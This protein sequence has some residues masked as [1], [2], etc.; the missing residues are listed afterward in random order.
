MSELALILALMMSP[1]ARAQEAPKP[2]IAPV[3]QE[4]KDAKAQARLD[5]SGAKKKGKASYYDGKLSGRKMAN[6]ER[7]DPQANTAASRTLPLGTRARVTN[8]HNGRSAEVEITDRGPF[9][10]GRTMDVTPKVAEELGMKTQGVAAVEVAP[11]EVPQQDGSVKP[12]A[13]AVRYDAGAS[14]GS[15][16]AS[17]PA[18]PGTAR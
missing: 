4:Q 17:T 1:Q 15:P 18:G 2:P 12:G 3:A 8:L 7:M 9:V 13:G 5:R 16:G 6:G 14:M 10:R 11:I